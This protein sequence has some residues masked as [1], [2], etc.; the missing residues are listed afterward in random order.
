VG[1]FLEVPDGCKQDAAERN[2][3]GLVEE[4]TNQEQDQAPVRNL[5]QPDR[6]RSNFGTAPLGS[7]ITTLELPLQLSKKLAVSRAA[8]S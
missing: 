3:G 2:P 7:T 8:T 4:R 6:Y 1:H 5:K